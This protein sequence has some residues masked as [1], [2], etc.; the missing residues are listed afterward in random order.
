MSVERS[1]EN[2]PIK[3]PKIKVEVIDPFE[4]AGITIKGFDI[5]DEETGK[6]IRVCDNL[7]KSDNPYQVVACSISVAE[8]GKL[9]FDL[10]NQN[11]ER[12]RDIYADINGIVFRF[13]PGESIPVQIY[14]FSQ[15]TSEDIGTDLQRRILENIKPGLSD[16]L[17]EGK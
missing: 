10:A 14:G 9:F 5:T 7:G 13:N 8:G 2:E 6:S 3:S 12:P 1:S 4:I 16:L 11:P 17:F 15:S